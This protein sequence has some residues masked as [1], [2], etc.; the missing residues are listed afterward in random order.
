MPKKSAVRDVATCPGDLA[1]LDES[2]AAS[3]S[4]KSKEDTKM[5]TGS[6]T[7]NK[8][9]LTPADSASSMKTSCST[10]TG[11]HGQGS[12][13]KAVTFENCDPVEVDDR[14]EE[15]MELSSPVSVLFYTLQQ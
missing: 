4:D 2:P 15:A 9:P 1:D 12:A 11:E 8:K 5:D 7:T 14:K 3:V 10:K 13:T 6:P